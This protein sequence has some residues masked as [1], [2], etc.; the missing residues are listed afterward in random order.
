V[1]SCFQNIIWFHD[2]RGNLILFTPIRNVLP[3]FLQFLQNSLISDITVCRSLIPKFIQI[4]GRRW[5]GGILR[6]NINVFMLLS[7]VCS[8][9]HENQ[10]Y[11]KKFCG[12][13]PF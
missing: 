6:M 5:G 12:N 3:F 13:I 2:T 10:N 9:F 7:N 11:S 4:R 1:H 8:D